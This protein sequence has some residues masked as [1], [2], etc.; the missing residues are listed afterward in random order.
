M[1]RFKVVMTDDRHKTY[2]EEKQILSSIDAEVI[3]SNC[4]TVEEV[5]NACRDAD[6]IMVN[7]APITAEVVDKLEK[8]KVIARYGVGYDNVD[9][10]ACTAKGIYVTNVTDYCAEE[11]SDHALA[12]LMACV[13][14]VARRDAQVR[15]GK[16]NIGSAD[17]I[18]RMAGKIFTFLGYG[19]IARTLH[20]KIKGFNFSRILVYD[21]YVDAEVIKAAGAEKVDWETAIK[22]A[23]Y[24]SIHMPLNDKTRGIINSETFAM[25]KPTAIIV[26]TSRGAVIEEQALIN[27]LVS[28]Q[29]NSAGLDV[30]N[31]EPLDAD[32]PLM[33]LEN[34]VLTDHVGWYSED[35]MSELKRKVAENVRDVLLGK[36]PKYPV[37]KV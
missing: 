31:K 2:E 12:L 17:P 1:A 37:N 3:I 14:K 33:K 25:M 7:L 16:W 11:V 35:S 28:G 24:I 9:V 4:S 30:H 13:R 32:N 20:R 23:D 22:E 6:G 5:I 19:M 8:C 18:Y 29:I 26:N 34:C 15:A 27:A 21:P 36:K 10:S